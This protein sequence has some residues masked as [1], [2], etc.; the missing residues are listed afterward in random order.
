MTSLTEFEI[1]PGTKTKPKIF[2]SIRRM[3][4]L[5]ESIDQRCISVP[6]QCVHNTH[7]RGGKLGISVF[8]SN[9]VFRK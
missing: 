4:K 2:L 7:V 9:F 6:V 5:F 8:R 1:F 3:K